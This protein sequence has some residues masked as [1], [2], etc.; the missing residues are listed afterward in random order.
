MTEKI[1]C[2]L[3]DHPMESVFT[4]TVLNKYKVTF[5]HC[6]DCGLLKSE[7]PYWLEES[8]QVAIADTDTG[9]VGRNITNRF[10]LMPILQRL[11][12]GKGK[13][14]D[15][16][17]GYGLL[18]RLMR[19]MGFDCYSTDKY[20]QNL[21]AKSFEPTDGF[22]A[23]ALFAFEILEH[24]VDPYQ[25]IKDIFTQYHCKTLVFSTLTFEGGIPPKDWWYYSFE[26]G[27]HITFYE[28]RTLAYLAKRLGCEYYMLNPGFHVITNRKLSMLDSLFIF[29]RYFRKL[30]TYFLFWKRKNLSLVWDDSRKA[31]AL[32]KEKLPS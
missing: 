1:Q 3:S 20:C 11:F 8:Y 25:F 9:L 5:Y 21:F 13:F 31:Q 12:R 24:V 22:K 32:L 2:P 29:N 19:D 18:T 30:Y 14:L 15:V 16:A 10:L 28:P 27:Q 6:E 7:H 23:D 26:A 4:E 17:G